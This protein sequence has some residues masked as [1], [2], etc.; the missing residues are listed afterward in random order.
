MFRLSRRQRENTRSAFLNLMTVALA[1]LVGGNLLNPKGF[2]LPIFIVG[3][4]IVVVS[5][6]SRIFFNGHKVIFAWIGTG[7]A[8][9][10]LVGSFGLGS[11][12]AQQKKSFLVLPSACHAGDGGV[13]YVIPDIY[14]GKAILVPIDLKNNNKLGNGFM[15]I[16]I[17]ALSCKLEYSEMGG[18][19]K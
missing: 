14:E 6:I 16:D 13:V 10:L 5:Y 12:I 19:T 9:I 4:I 11:F 8:I 7:L 2:N 18:V 17:S 15:L 1:T 3:C